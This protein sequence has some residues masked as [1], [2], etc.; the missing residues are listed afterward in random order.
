MVKDTPLHS[1]SSTSLSSLFRPTKLKNLSAKIFN[2]GGNQSN[3]KADNILRPSSKSSKKLADS[4]QEDYINYNKPNYRGST[5]G[6]NVPGN[7]ASSKESS[8]PTSARK[9]L[10]DS[11]SSRPPHSNHNPVRAGHTVPHLPHSIHN[12]I[13]YIHQSSKDSFHHPHPVR[14]TAQNKIS[15]VSSAKSDTSPNLSYQAHMHPVEILQKQIEDRH[16]M[17]SQA[18]TPGSVDLHHNSSSGSDDT[19][20]KKK[21]S[22]RLTR[23]FKK[24][25]NDYH[26]NHH[27][28]HHYHNRG[29]TP[30]KPNVNS[31][32]NE[33]VVDNNGKTLY[34]TDNPV[35]LLEKY[36]IPGRKLGEGASGSV[37]VVERT[38][39]KLFACKMFRKP[40][41][42]NEGTNHSQ[43]ANYSK[44]VTTEF[45]IGSTL[46]HENIIETLDMLT[47]GET[48]LLVMEYAPYDFFNLVMSNLMTQSEVNCYFKQLCH[49]VNYLHSMG[50]AHRDLKLDNCVVTK[51]GIL[52]L[53]DFGSAVVFQYPY[54]DTIVKSHGI[55]GSDPYLAPELL[56]QT[57]YDPRVAD[58][59]SIAIIFYCMVL[60]RFPWKAP[61]KSFN[62]FRLFTEEPEDED[63]IARG[64][65]KILRLLPRDSRKIIGKMLALEPKQRVLM[66]EVVKDDWLVSVPSCETDPTSGNLVKKPKSHKH[67]LVTEE[68]LNELTKQYGN[69]DSN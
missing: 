41:L 28:H 39:G 22:L 19:S 43:L 55:V 57:S 67:H 51:D 65:N 64:P 68:E 10:V 20:S 9:A 40:H 63:D 60:K 50:L 30:T 44:K 58:V 53:I 8:A 27:H 12:P 15:T 47:E 14:P 66:N 13:N 69:K 49:G 1:S 26:D 11:P 21:K 62:S 7:S 35:E 34:E 54:E 33:S 32:T 5:T 29:S 52:K 59:W 56:K 61:K 36:G 3:S 16:F 24:I 45:C 4:D 42:N 18:S 46:H 31:N 37:S 6:K 48:Y 17:D 25:H 2:G 23:F 38:D